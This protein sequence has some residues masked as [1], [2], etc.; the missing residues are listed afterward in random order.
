MD[1]NMIK[2]SYDGVIPR[3]VGSKIVPMRRIICL[4]L[5]TLGSNMVCASPNMLPCL[6]LP[7]IFC[8][9]LKK[10]EC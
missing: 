1:H 6:G 10:I 5:Y 4:N 7:P 9:Y 2:L 8:N 3:D